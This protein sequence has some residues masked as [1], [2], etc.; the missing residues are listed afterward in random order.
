MGEAGGALQTSGSMGGRQALKGDKLEHW[1]FEERVLHFPKCILRCRGNFC[2]T[3]VRGQ[4]TRFTYYLQQRLEKSFDEDCVR[5]AR[6]TVTSGY[7]A[8]GMVVVAAS[9]LYF[10]RNSLTSN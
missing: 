2:R 6:C 4:F 3:A 5:Y 7:R 9:S 10:A 1:P 8:S